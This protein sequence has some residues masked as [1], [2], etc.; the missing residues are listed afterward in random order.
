LEDGQF[1]FGFFAFDLLLDSLGHP[2][3]FGFEGV[4]NLSP[5]SVILDP[6]DTLFPAFKDTCHDSTS[7]VVLSGSGVL[8]LAGGKNSCKLVAR[9]GNENKAGQT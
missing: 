5:V 8:S 9:R 4:I 2:R 6:P 1:L 7:I 3:V